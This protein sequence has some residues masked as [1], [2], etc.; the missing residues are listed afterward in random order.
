MKL[1]VVYRLLT[2]VIGLGFTLAFLYFGYTGWAVAILVLTV[3][4]IFSASGHSEEG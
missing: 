3:A 1:L 2:M 4:A